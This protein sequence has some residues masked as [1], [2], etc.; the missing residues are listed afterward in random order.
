MEPFTWEVELDRAKASGKV[1]AILTFNTSD[2]V[3]VANEP[4]RVMGLQFYLAYKFNQEGYHVARFALST[5]MLLMDPPNGQK[6]SESPFNSL[7]NLQDP[8]QVLVSLGRILRQPENRCVLLIDYADHVA[9]ATGDGMAAALSNDQRATLEILHSWGLDDDIKATE[10]FVVMVSHENALHSLVISGGGFASI[11]I[12]LPDERNRQAFAE[13]MMN[14]ADNPDA[15]VKLGKLDQE[16]TTDMF[17]R[18]TGGLRLSDI[19]EMFHLAG[20]TG[21]PITSEWVRENKKKSIQQICNDLVEIIEPTEGFEGVAGAGSVKEYFAELKKLWGHGLKSIPQALMLVGPPGTGKSHIVYALA[22]ELGCPCLVMRGVRDKWVGSSER[23][24]DLVLRVVE[25]LSPCILFTDEIDQVIG[26]ERSGS[27]SGDSGTSERILGRIFE[28]FGGM[29]HRGRI[30][31]VAT[32]NRPDVLDCALLD[33]FQD[34]LPLIHPSLTERMELLPILARQIDRQFAEEV[35]L[36]E[37]AALP[38]LQMVT[39]RSLQEIVVKAAN[40][41]DGATGKLGG[42]ISQERLMQTINA[43]CG[44]PNPLEHEYWSLI[45]LHMTSF[46]HYLPW[47]GTNGLRTDAQW[48]VYLNDLVDTDTGEFKQGALSKRLR[49]LDDLFGPANARARWG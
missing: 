6:K 14:V 47:M 11:P 40:A 25:N 37:L 8:R 33:R 18:S 1:G 35:S 32:T 29:K 27:S 9:P 22:K 3:F 16:M 21:E 31:W 15:P 45:A 4:G 44:L 10:N 43:Y 30:L 19:E 42:E 49:E 41:S 12:N 38:K 20:A 13:F 5:G 17:A 34:V 2:R 36:H 46:I 39:N 26:G 28:F 23:N 48:P 7:C 24:L